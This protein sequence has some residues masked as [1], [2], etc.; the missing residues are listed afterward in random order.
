M[1]LFKRRAAPFAG[2]L[3]LIGTGAISASVAVARPTQATAFTIGSSLAGPKVLP[4]RV[5]WVGYPSA[6]VGVRGVDFLIDGKLVMR[7]RQEPH[8]FGEVGRDA[9]GAVKTG[10]LVTSWLTPGKHPFTVRACS[11]SPCYTDTQFPGAR[12]A[13]IA[14]KTVVARVVAAPTPPAQLAGRWTKRVPRAIPGDPGVLYRGPAAAG[15]YRMVIDSRFIQHLDPHGI[16]INS[17]YS[18]TPTSFT[19]GAPVWT[20]PAK[21]LPAKGPLVQ[22]NPREGAWCDPWG[23]DAT[24]TWSVSGNTLT[25]TPQGGTDSCKQRGAVMTGDWTRVG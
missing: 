17:D 4:H 23:P 25:L 1:I 2:L 5:R 20:T 8:A 21:P 7:N 22:K 24:Y 11:P 12:P 10:F 16:A 6:N 18:A 15:T 13:V 3:V 9:S 19:I 14:T